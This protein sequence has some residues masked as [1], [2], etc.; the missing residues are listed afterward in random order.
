MRI[1][2]LLIPSGEI[3][4]HGELEQ[5]LH[6][7]ARIDGVLEKEQQFRCTYTFPE[8]KKI[9]FGF[10]RSRNK[11]HFIMKCRYEEIAAGFLISYHVFPAFS[12]CCLAAFPFL[13]M[14]YGLF[15]L[16]ERGQWYIAFLSGIIA[17]ALCYPCLMW[18]RKNCINRFEQSFS[19]E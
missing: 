16:A 19:K 15:G 3:V 9:Q 13:A 17:A 12:S 11:L 2:E 7:I 1:K 6:T 4:F 5:L 8:P 10:G 18:A 14:V